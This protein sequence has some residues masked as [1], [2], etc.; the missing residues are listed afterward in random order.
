MKILK[1]KI[2]KAY[3]PFILAEM[4]GN[5]NQSLDRA[6]EIVA[7]VAKCGCDGIKLQTYTPDTMTLDIQKKE[8]IINDKKSLW[9]GESLYDLYGKAMTPW[10]WH[11]P[12]FAK[13]AELGLIAFSSPFDET[14]VDF[15][16][17]LNVPA[18]KIAS[19]E[20][21]DMPLL[22]KIA[23]TG[24]PVIMSTGMATIS[25]LAESVQCLRDNGC[26][27]LM[28]LK[29]TST[30]PSTAE[31]SN[32]LTIPHMREM[33]NCEIGLS[34]HTM[35]LGTSIASIALGS[36]LI[37][38]HF[39]LS[40]KDGGVDADFSIEPNEMKMLVYESKQAWKALGIIS[41]GTD[42]EKPSRKFRRSLYIAKNMIKGDSL[43][44]ENLRVIRPGFGLEP[45]Y[46]EILLGK[47]VNC[48]LRK[49]TAM[50]W[51]II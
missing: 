2:G 1:R 44:K 7:Q 35:G 31:N 51:D 49:G 32:L 25:E 50:S 16:E 41:Y 20:N 29:C 39:T 3:P 5:H 36:T 27:D 34:D 24:K 22:K 12:I 10:E 38:K 40:R 48:D 47:K 11:K 42:I 23:V 8:F 30:Y 21:I 15:L 13:C 19:F 6:L 4:S 14:S 17:T 26:E 9:Y 18:Y 33:F 45:K 28:L 37:E 46:Y 43:T